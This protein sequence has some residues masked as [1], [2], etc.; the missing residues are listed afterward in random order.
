MA[1]AFSP[2]SPRRWPLVAALGSLLLGIGAV[3]AWSMN[4]PVY[5]FSS[6]PVGDAVD[7]VEVEEAEIY[8]PQGELIMLTVSSQEVN[9]FEAVAAA[10]D[11]DVDLVPREAVRPRDETDEE[12]VLRNRSL[13]DTSTET[14]ITLA[15]QRLGYAITP[16]SDG[17]RIAE[18]VEDTPAAAVLEVDD[19]I[20]GVAGDE[21][22]VAEDLGPIVTSFE[23]GDT[24]D[25][26]I[27]RGETEE[28]VTVELVPRTDDPNR[29][30]IG[31]SVETLNPRFNFPFPIAIEAGQI[32]GP[33]AGMMYTLAV[34]DLLAPDDL[35]KGHVI[36]GTGT[37]DLEG[38]VGAIGGV[39]QKVV[40]AEAAGAEYMLVPQANLVE[41]ESARRTRMELVGVNNLDDALA[42]L[43]TLPPV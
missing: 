2:P 35:T 20:V 39:R 17:I 43:A 18:V 6:G 5:A 14:A 13:M 36:A 27:R 34:M 8:T 25:L 19:V 1:E 28:N 23:V 38:N 12:F 15:L 4:L 26:D 24:I 22:T 32:G 29:P 30:M 31:I 3:A 7:V 9:L 11:P 37:I 10:I 41:A 16:A 21:V 40:A 33:S 42:F